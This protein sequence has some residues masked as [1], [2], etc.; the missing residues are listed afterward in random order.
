MIRTLIAVAAVAAA[1]TPALAQ[2]A[3]EPRGYGSL[4][5]TQLE[6]DAPSVGAVTG[7]L[8]VD[9]NR[10]LAFETEAS[11]GVKD[12]DFAVAGVEGTREHVW[13]AAGYVVGKAPIGDRINL[14]ARGGYGHTELNSQ[15]AGVETD[16]GGDSWNYGAG[17]EV[18][19]GGQTGLR[20]DWTRRDFRE[21][22]RDAD[23]YSLSLV[24]RF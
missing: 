4:G 12:N 3:A 13:D 5:Y 9:L 10:W 8:G 2:S 6:G 17:A 21:G 24:R 19:L 23:A 20:A 18:A 14:F 16:I 11:I 22:D 1:S 7:R 15:L